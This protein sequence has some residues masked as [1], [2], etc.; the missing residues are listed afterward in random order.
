M[1]TPAVSVVIP[2]H[3][4]QRPLMRLLRALECQEPVAGGFEVVVVTDGSTDSTAA[5]V[6]ATAWTIPVTVIEQ[7][8]AGPAEARNRGASHARGALLLFL[9]DDVEPVPG[10]VRAHQAFHT[11]C[12]DGVGIGDLPPAVQAEGLF[13]VI[14]RGW[15]Q[16]MFDGSRHGGHRYLYRDLLSGHCSI[17]RANFETIGRFDPALRCHEDWELGY[18]AI[19]CGLSLRL[20]PGAVAIHHEA[21][22]LAKAL[23]RKYDEGVADIQLLERHAAL[24][25]Q[26]PLSRTR[27]RGFAG[28]VLVSMVWQHGA[29]AD[30]LARAFRSFLSVY[31]YVNLRFRW[32]AL[33]EDLLDYWYWRG[34]AHAAG[35]RRRLDTLLDQARAAA[36]IGP[37]PEVVLDL[38]RGM[39]AARAQLDAVRPRSVRLVYAGDLVG[40]EPA[41]GGA[42]RLRGVHLPRLIARRFA[43]PYV[44]A[45][46]RAGTLPATLSGT[47]PVDHGDAMADGGPQAAVAVSTIE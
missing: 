32:R 17:A 31:E 12:P 36:A 20:V 35:A 1:S 4:R 25:P 26:L 33:L 28:R 30:G 34:V 42:E 45:A 18:R 44:R 23:R 13:A 29:I 27:Q 3:N 16:Q 5:A 8:A 19:E 7:A 41:A 15:W 10:V 2:T 37:D 14:L 40:D 38:S 11:R 47:V 6:R 46:A 21:S 9:D 39:D 24:G 22:S 43:A